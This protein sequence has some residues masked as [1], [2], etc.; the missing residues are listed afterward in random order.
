MKLPQEV[1]ET[2]PLT[3]TARARRYSA[4]AKGVVTSEKG[5]FQHL[6][7]CFGEML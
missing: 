6:D 5:F 3:D 2:S 7:M 1:P 4:V